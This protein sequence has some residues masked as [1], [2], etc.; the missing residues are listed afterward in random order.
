MS[1]RDY[2]PSKPT[3]RVRIPVADCSLL[4]LLQ[5]QQASHLLSGPVSSISLVC[6][7]QQE[8]PQSNRYSLQYYSLTHV[9]LGNP[10]H[11]NFFCLIYS[12]SSYFFFS[13]LHLLSLLLLSLPTICSLLSCYLIFLCTFSLFSLPP[14]CSSSTVPRPLHLSPSCLACWL[15]SPQA[16]AYRLRAVSF[17]F[18]SLQIFLFPL[19]LTFSTSLQYTRCVCVCV[20]GCVTVYMTSTDDNY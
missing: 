9:S 7:K 16:Q 18:L 19:T 10:S 20:E 13:F 4:H 11:C 8:G 2:E 17:L 15:V 14:S 6:Q 12:Y 3:A 5:G 1:V